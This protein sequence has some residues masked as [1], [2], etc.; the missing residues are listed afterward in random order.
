MPK[1]GQ[2][3]GSGRKNPYGEPTK[4]IPTSVPISREKDFKIKAKK[5][6]KTYHIKK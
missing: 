6:L 2:R 3:T 4:R 1:G 5:I